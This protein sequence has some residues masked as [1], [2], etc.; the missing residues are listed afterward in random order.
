MHPVSVVIL[1][2]NEEFNIEACLDCLKFSDDVVVYDSY[3]DDS[4]VELA[5]KYDNVRVVQ[6]KFDNWSTH[7]NWGV[8]NIEFR[9]P[10]VLY[11]DADERV[12]EDLADEIQSLCDPDSGYSAFR[13]RRKDMFMGRWLKRAQLYPTWIVRVFRP[14]KISYERLVNP[15]AVVD[16]RTGDLEG[17][18]MHYPFSKGI[19]DWID[20]HNKYSNWEAEELLK[21]RAGKRTPLKNLFGDAT[22]RRACLKDIFFRLPLRPQI[23]W[24]Y[25]MCW[26]MAWLDGHAGWSYARLTYL[27]EYMISMKVKEIKLKR[28]G[29]SV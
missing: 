19:V 7:Q 28:A 24:L 25:Y 3:S 13:L 1:T 8:E 12:P 16:G 20:R 11:V 17:H 22:E 27:Y 23:K 4:T 29:K 26:R 21:V 2:K 6:R 9:H 5:E 14:E 15:I 18:L 10:W